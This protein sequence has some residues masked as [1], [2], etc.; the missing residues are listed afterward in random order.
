MWHL[1]HKRVVKIQVD[2]FIAFHPHWK[3]ATT[4]K[5]INLSLSSMLALICCFIAPIC[6]IIAVV[7]TQDD[8][9]SATVLGHILQLTTQQ[10]SDSDMQVVQSPF[11]LALVFNL[12]W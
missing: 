4:T 5:F 12:F 8:A 2:N 11:F 9:D 3:T 10:C 7:L 1:R 6:I